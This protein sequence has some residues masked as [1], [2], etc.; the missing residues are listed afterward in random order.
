MQVLFRVSDNGMGIEPSKLDS[1]FQPFMQIDRTLDRA[2]GG[3]GIGL[4]LVRRLVEMQGG[5]VSARSPGRGRGSAFTI[6]MPMAPPRTIVVPAESH[7]FAAEPGRPL[8]VLVVDDNRDVASSMALVLRTAGHAVFVSH[9]GREAIETMTRVQPD[10]V[11]LDIGLP[12]AD[13]FE[14]ARR[15]RANPDYARTLLVAISGYGQDDHRMLSRAAGFDHHLVKPVEPDAVLHLLATV[16]AGQQ[17]AAG[18][19]PAS[20]Q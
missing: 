4:T 13:G 16:P 19:L 1:I 20:K 9:D 2:Q 10:A 14:V 15:I 6:R 7:A 11:L 5:Q 8:N 12:G 18:S 17:G 3:L